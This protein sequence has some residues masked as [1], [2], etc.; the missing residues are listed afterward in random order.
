MNR[1]ALPSLPCLI[2][3]L[4]GCS[5]GTL[6]ELNG[7]SPFLRQQ[8]NQDLQFGPTFHEQVAELELLES[9][10]AS[11]PPAEQ[12]FRVRQ[13]TELIR[14]SESTLMRVH[15]VRALAAIP[16]PQAREGLDMASADEEAEVRIA[17]CQ[18]WQRRG[19]PAAAQALGVLLKNDSDIDVRL[20]AARSLGA[21]QDPSAVSAL[22][23]ALDDRDPA[24]QVRVMESLGKVTGKNYGH[25]IV[26][27]RAFLSGQTPP[28]GN[29]G[30][31]RRFGFGFF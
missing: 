21:V 23:T 18:A 12:Q 27:W 19:G 11:L 13:L 14:D 4:T 31:A 26:S 16:L 20:A 17:A 25:D 15:S 6:P 9:N 10:A 28:P 8:W 29:A 5:D 3:L 7:A 24:L 2:L 30:V 1:Y 22:A